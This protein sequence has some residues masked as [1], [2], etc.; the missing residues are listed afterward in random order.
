MSTEAVSTLDSARP[1][2]AC[3][4]NLCTMLYGID[5]GKFRETMVGHAGTRISCRVRGGAWRV[6]PLR[7]VHRGPGIA[8]LDVQIWLLGSSLRGPPVSS[9]G[10]NGLLI[11]GCPCSRHKG[12]GSSFFLDV[13]RD[14]IAEN[15]RATSA[16][17]SWNGVA[18]GRHAT[19]SPSATSLAT[20]LP[21]PVRQRRNDRARGVG[22][23]SW[24]LR[25][26]VLLSV[27]PFPV[28]RFPFRRCLMRHGHA[29]S[30]NHS[31]KSTLLLAVPPDS[32]PT[33]R[34]TFLH[35]CML[36][37]EPLTAA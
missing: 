30:L 35:P 18:T 14:E 21:R 36:R 26:F 11:P 34:D 28:S 25:H 37:F 2:C 24:A 17:A 8:D 23:A 1:P 16:S 9:C 27:S 6:G 4:R 33:D 29:R 3:T 31:S 10:V 20:Q 12:K 5:Y 19:A 15:T 13:C 22:A 32:R 7:A